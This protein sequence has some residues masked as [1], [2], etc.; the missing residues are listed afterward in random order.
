MTPTGDRKDALLEAGLAL[1]SDLSLD[2]ILR[3]IVELAM[4]LTGARYGALGVLGPDRVIEEFVTIGVT[5]QQRQRIG[6]PPLGRGILGALIDGARPLRLA[7]ISHDPRSFGFP[8]NHPPMASFLGAPVQARGRVFGNIYLTE[9]QGAREFTEED[10]Q[11]LVVLAAQAG[12]AVSN[13]HLYEDTRRRERWLDAVAET[14]TTILAGADASSTLELVADRARGL[15]GADLASIAIPE[16]GDTL[17]IVAAC[18]LHAETLRGEVFP[19]EG[20]LSGEAMRTGTTIVVADAAA[21]GRVIQPV[22]RAGDLGPAM[23]VPMSARGVPFGTLTVASAHGGRPFRE[24]D[25][26][27][28]ASFAEQAA[29]A[30]QY[31]R[32]QDELHRLA[33]LEDRERIARELHDGVIQSLFAVGMGLQGSAMLT[34]DAD[35]AARIEGA[36]GELD[37]VIRDLRNYIFGLRPGILADR[38]LDQALRDLAADLEARSGVTTVVDI[39]AGV[40]AELGSR[41]PDVIQFVREALSNVGRHAHASTCRVTLRRVSGADGTEAMIEVDDDGQGF[42]VHRAKEG[43]G[44]PNLRARASAIRGAVALE[45]TPGEGTVVRLTL[46]L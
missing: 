30:V 23:F 28:V 16:D 21:D 38:Q 32:A 22:V 4:D 3:R 26:A 33:V 10:E 5:P 43:N 8:P 25:R 34:H 27:L 44:V 15:L 45:S 24:D 39:D 37:R 42:D 41:A 19:V 12:M 29:L 17:R 40:A 36:V 46:P 14:S 7:D 1:S 31:A 11:D 13:A 18:G 2:V 6:H 9:K 20:S 35:V